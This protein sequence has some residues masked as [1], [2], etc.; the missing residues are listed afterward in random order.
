MTRLRALPSRGVF[1]ARLLRRLAIAIVIVACSL[2]IGACGYHWTE[3][4]PWLD[5][6]LNA[7]MILTGMGPVNQLQTAAGKTF[8]IFYSLF[9]GVVFI[10]T[11]AVI[12]GPMVHR[13][14]HK[15]RLEIEPQESLR[16]E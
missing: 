2:F 3:D 4:L 7:S 11:M 15:H 1:A 10:T 8:A 13:F 14:L 5:A 12:L 6:T 16:D 9:G